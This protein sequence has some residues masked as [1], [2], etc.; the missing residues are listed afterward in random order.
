METFDP[1]KEATQL[2]FVLTHAELLN[3]KRINKRSE[4]QPENE[5]LLEAK[6]YYIRR[7][8]G[9]YVT[10]SKQKPKYVCKYVCPPSG[11]LEGERMQQIGEY[12]IYY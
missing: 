5:H 8:P 11:M 12:V 6:G 10:I 7:N 9:H 4:I 1:T 3:F 2:M